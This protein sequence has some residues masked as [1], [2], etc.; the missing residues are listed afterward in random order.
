MNTSTATS[1]RPLGHML[2][3]GAAPTTDQPQYRYVGDCRFVPAN[4]AAWR[5]VERWNEYAARVTARSAAAR[6][7][8]VE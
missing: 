3:S 7:S 2:T 8:A 5:E 1:T 6:G 4:A